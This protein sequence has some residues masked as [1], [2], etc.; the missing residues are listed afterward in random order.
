MA[1]DLST[2]PLSQKLQRMLDIGERIAE[3]QKEAKALRAA[4]AVDAECVGQG[5]PSATNVVR[6]NLEGWTVEVSKPADEQLKDWNV[7][8]HRAFTAK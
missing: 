1:I 6:V 7:A 5:K 2:V 4:V 8:F 3:L